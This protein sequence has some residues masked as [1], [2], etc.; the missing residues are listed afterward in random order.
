MLSRKKARERIE[1]L[2]QRNQEGQKGFTEN[3]VGDP[4]Q[5]EM[6]RESLKPSIQTFLSDKK[7]SR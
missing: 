3:T 5:G 4:L 2:K 1:F 6:L 7:E